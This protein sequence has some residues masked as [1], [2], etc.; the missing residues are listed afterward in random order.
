MSDL[1]VVLVNHGNTITMHYI[2]NSTRSIFDSLVPITDV[3]GGKVHYYGL[4]VQRERERE[5]DRE[6]EKLA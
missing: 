3:L 2:A 1:S 6:R 4:I 5:R